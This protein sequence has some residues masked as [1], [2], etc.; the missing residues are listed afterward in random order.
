M[1]TAG[2]VQ[3]IK[4]SCVGSLECIRVSSLHLAFKA[5][6][7]FVP[8]KEVGYIASDYYVITLLL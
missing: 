8:Q 4:Y 2:G 3:L 6:G 7:V 5:V 1:F